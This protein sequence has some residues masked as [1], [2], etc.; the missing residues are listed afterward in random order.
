MSDFNVLIDGFLNLWPETHIVMLI[1]SSYTEEEKRIKLMTDGLTFKHKT[2]RANNNFTSARK[3]RYTVM[4]SH[5]GIIDMIFF[6]FCFV[7]YLMFYRFIAFLA[8]KTNP[9][10]LLAASFEANSFVSYQITSNSTSCK[11]K[12]F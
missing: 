1:F 9:K 2:K 3:V 5:F 11:Y 4:A 8:A 6:I 12:Y 10:R 7:S